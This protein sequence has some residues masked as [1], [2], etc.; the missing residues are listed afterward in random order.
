MKKSPASLTYRKALDRAKT[1]LYIGRP[2]EG[3]DFSPLEIAVAQM[4]IHQRRHPD[5]LQLRLS[6]FTPDSRSRIRLYTLLAR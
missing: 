6:R 1:C 3:D 5:V 4:L 2:V